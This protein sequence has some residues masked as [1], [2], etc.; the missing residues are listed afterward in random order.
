MQI[1]ATRAF[2]L[3]GKRVEPGTTLEVEDPLARLLVAANKA[4]RA[5]A[6]P[7]A[8]PMTTKTAA[9]VVRG[10]AAEEKAHAG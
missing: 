10:K 7:P 5:G 9:A 4:E 1:T 8:G 2:L 3:G 6:A